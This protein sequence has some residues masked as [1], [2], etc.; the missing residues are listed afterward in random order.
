[1]RKRLYTLLLII[2]LPACI[3]TP[4]TPPRESQGPT[5]FDSVTIE[6]VYTERGKPSDAA[7][8]FLTTNLKTLNIA[9][10][11][12]IVRRQVVYPPIVP[13]TTSLIKEFE[14]KHRLIIDQD[15]ENR[16][17]K[18]FIAYLPDFYLQGT[19]NN[20]AGLQYE[21]SSFAVFIGKI[22]RKHEGS[23]LLHEFG[24]IIGL[25]ARDSREG[26]PVNPD[27][28]SHCNDTKC[29][30]FWRIPGEDA[31]FDDACLGDLRSSISD[32]NPV[33]STP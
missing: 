22:K 31:A 10:Q 12:I 20:I 27:R 26:A 28:P 30:M 3:A 32:R 8:K 11:I 5:Y 15:P 9:S 2:L 24:H 1:M 33:I 6:L 29:V 21:D 14:K 7:L 13:W 16:H 19:R 18:L 23:V 4:K 17:L 25:V